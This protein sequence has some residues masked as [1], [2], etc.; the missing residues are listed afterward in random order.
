MAFCVGCGKAVVD[1]AKFCDACGTAIDVSMK[2][3]RTQR[4]TVYDGALH[5]CPNCGERLNAFVTTCPVCNYELRG[6]KVTSCVH[7]LSQKLEKTDSY[8][9]KIDLISNFYI[10]NTKEDIYEFFILAY[11]YVSSGAYDVDAWSVKLEQAYLKAK[12]AFGNSEE[13]EYIK[14]LYEKLNISPSK[15][16]IMNSKNFKSVLLLIIGLLL[17]IAG[18]L[19]EEILNEYEIY[20]KDALYP[21]AAI[22]FVCFIVG[23]VL[24]LIPNVK[25][26]KYKRKN[27]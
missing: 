15:N 26:R 18:L 14:E 7:E 9:Q 20:M 2:S 23:L 22:G 11:S 1:E 17:F 5:K 8:E 13:Y 19:T 3:E 16:R 21:I 10:P 12:L 24:F 25:K 6:T 4:Q 27:R